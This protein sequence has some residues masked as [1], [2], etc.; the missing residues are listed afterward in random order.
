MHSM[1]CG[2]HVNSL[3]PLY[4]RAFSH[5]ATTL[6]AVILA[7]VSVGVGIPAHADTLPLYITN[8][9]TSTV[10]AYDTS[11]ATVNASLISGL[12]GPVGIAVASPVPLPA[13]AVLFP[14]GLGFLAIAFRKLRTKGSVAV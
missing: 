4:N 13:A 1:T 14:T 8:Y 2:E 9:N 12:S 3:S 5:V 7:N 11:G 10:G 6:V